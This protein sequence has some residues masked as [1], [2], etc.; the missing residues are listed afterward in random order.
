MDRLGRLL[1][2]GIGL[3]FAFFVLPRLMHGSSD[4][5]PL[6]AEHLRAATEA[7]PPETTC[8]I[9]SDDFHAQLSSRGA[10]L[11]HFELLRAKYR[12][13]GKPIDLSTTPDVENRRQLRLDWQN[14][15]LGIKDEDW[16]VGENLLDF[17]IV[18]STQ[19]SCEFAF[20][21]AQA[22]VHETVRAT[23]RPYELEIVATVKNNASRPLKHALTVDTDAWRT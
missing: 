10:S 15:A 23:G 16:L 11:K 21:D 4:L 22:E 9:W 5:Q 3:I 19:S 14:P 20:Q 12:K 18:G 7:R 1:F 17:R 2:I 6:R 8:D 13:K